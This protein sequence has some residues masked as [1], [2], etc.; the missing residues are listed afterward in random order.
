M[1][2]EEAEVQTVW[3][4]QQRVMGRKKVKEEKGGGGWGGG[5]KVLPTSSGTKPLR[6]SELAFGSS[7]GPTLLGSVNSFCNCL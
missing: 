2:R 3:S 5:E 7:S 1:C 6:I 4:Q